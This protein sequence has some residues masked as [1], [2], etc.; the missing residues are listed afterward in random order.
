MS[1]SSNHSKITTA[2]DPL[3]PAR[4]LV[5]NQIAISGDATGF[6]G[7]GT[8]TGT[9]ADGNNDTAIGN[10]RIN[11][12]WS[13]VGSSSCNEHEKTALVKIIQAHKV[14][15]EELDR[16]VSAVKPSKVFS[17]KCRKALFECL[18][19]WNAAMKEEHD[20]GEDTEMQ[21]DK[22]TTEPEKVAASQE[23]E[24]LELLK[25]T[26]SA[27]HLCDAILPLLPST[28]MDAGYSEGPFGVPGAAS[29]NFVRYLRARHMEGADLVEDGISD[30]LES[31]HPDEYGDGSLYWR[32]METLTT[33]G[34]LEEAW[35]LLERH[36][37]YQ[38]AL[39][40]AQSSMQNHPGHVQTMQQ[41]LDDFH[42]LREVFLRAPLPGG[43][44]DENDDCLEDLTS[45]DDDN[46]M[47]TE[48]YLEGLNVTPSHYTFWEVDTT[49]SDIGD[50]PMVYAP[51]AAIKYHKNWQTYVQR[52]VRNKLA[53]SRRIPEVEKILSIICG[54]FTLVTFDDWPEQ[55]CADILYRRPDCRPR[56]LQVITKRAMQSFDAL[57]QPFAETILSIIDGN[58]GS[59][60]H[61][62]YN[63]G[64]ASGAALSTTLVRIALNNAFLFR[65]TVFSCSFYSLPFCSTCFSKL[66][67]CHPTKP[68]TRLNSSLALHLQLSRRLRRTFQPQQKTVMWVL[69]WQRACFYRTQ[70]KITRLRK[71]SLALQN[72]SNVT[73]RSP[74]RMQLISLIYAH[75]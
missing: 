19:S 18:L 36:S 15:H 27:M 12:L 43:R 62:F 9:S 8:G 37:L 58:A 60:I 6:A 7:A 68:S 61:T 28:A 23:R 31:T 1:E 10:L 25:I 67:L 72:S 13:H 40:F 4:L 33:R 38:S 21:D 69:F 71:S 56:D 55:L 35:K 20:E 66:A 29:A 22:E 24:N 42:I 34:L 14:Y 47:E 73:T 3:C 5:L 2:W 26:Y 75:H 46:A 59:A 48:Y 30:M 52:E 50:T 57:E 41:I 32:Y 74:T 45:Q 11:Y 53:I 63:M 17:R 44:N 64:A 51:E 49:D 65:E 54:D 39:A 16:E 70:C